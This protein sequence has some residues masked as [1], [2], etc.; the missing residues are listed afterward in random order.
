MVDARTKSGGA[1]KHF[2]TK[3]EAESFAAKQRIKRG[4][5]GNSAFAMPSADRNDAEAALELL[6]PHGRTLREAADF[7][8]KHLRIVETEKKVPAVIGELLMS[9][10][11]DGASVRYLK[12]LRTR[13]HIFAKSFDEDRLCDIS[14][15]RLDDW[16]RALPHTATTRNNYR[17]LIGVLFSYGVKR[18]YCLA[19]PAIATS[20]G[21]A[22]DK[23]PGILTP[24]QCARLL[25]NASDEILPALVFGMFAG[26]RP[27]AEVWRLDWSK[28]DLSAGLIH[29][30]ANSTKSARHR[31]V[32]IT[33]NLKAWLEPYARRS[34]PVSPT[35]DK[36]NYLLQS[37]REGAK[38]KDWPPD[39]LRHCFASYHYGHFQDPGRTMVQMGH[40]NPR[41]FHAHYRARV[42][43]TAA[44]AFWE[45]TPQ[46]EASGNVLQMT[47]AA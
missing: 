24:D 4:N 21:K 13:L 47:S 32:E 14:T 23:P 34:G 5:E 19:N 20:K 35:G 22:V 8:L 31:I 46:S 16:L 26:L 17:R 28:V 27:E 43:P 7:F 33:P 6:K 29:I 10:E 1:R 11:R 40:T 42:T 3:I 18:N 45:L 37:A 30:E 39:A 12:D 9:K 36:Y 44:F 41:T 15:A 2:P 25:E 38:V